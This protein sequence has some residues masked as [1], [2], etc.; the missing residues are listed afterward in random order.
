MS[1]AGVTASVEALKFKSV[2]PDVIA[3]SDLLT[4]LRRKLCFLILYAS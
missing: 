4:L 2:C 3:I 1:F